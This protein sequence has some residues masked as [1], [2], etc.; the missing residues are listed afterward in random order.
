MNL[1]I[2]NGYKFGK[3]KTNNAETVFIFY[4]RCFNVLCN[5]YAKWK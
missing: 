1:K 4:A 5:A 2:W 3:Q